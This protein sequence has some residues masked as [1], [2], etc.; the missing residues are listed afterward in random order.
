MFDFGDFLEAS[1]NDITR[2]PQI[3]VLTAEAFLFDG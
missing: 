2:D 1:E 3:V